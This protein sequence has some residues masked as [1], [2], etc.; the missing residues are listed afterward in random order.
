LKIPDPFSQDSLPCFSAILLL[1]VLKPE[2][3][4]NQIKK[5]VEQAL[6][7]EFTRAAQWSLRDI[8]DNNSKP[9]TPILL[10]LTPGNDPIENI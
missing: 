8:Y 9:S 5:Y 3:A 4:I 7:S 10:L 2:L 1:K 6:G